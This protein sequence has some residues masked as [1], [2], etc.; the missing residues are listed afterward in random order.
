MENLVKALDR[1]NGRAMAVQCFLVALCRTLPR[2]TLERT[3][4]AFEEEVE[5]AK[6]MLLNT[7]ATEDALDA[8]D[9][10]AALMLGQL[11]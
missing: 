5:T 11:E 8:L 6:T 7:S 2:D 10:S 1:Q 3:L 4:N 9:A